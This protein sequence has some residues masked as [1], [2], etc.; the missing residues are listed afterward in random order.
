MDKIIHPKGANSD[1]IF[2]KKLCEFIHKLTRTHELHPV[3]L[4]F[5]VIDE[6]ILML[7]RHKILNTVDRLFERQLRSKEPNE[8]LFYLFKIFY[9]FDSFM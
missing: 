5:N 8:V 2:P 4:I 6:D 3:K 9:L 1:E 7:H